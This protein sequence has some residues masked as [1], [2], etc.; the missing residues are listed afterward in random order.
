MTLGDLLSALLIYKMP[1]LFPLIPS[2]KFF[3]EMQTIWLAV[4][5]A[6]YTWLTISQL[7]KHFS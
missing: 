4:L 2:L 6:V 5:M 1:F 3:T 7:T